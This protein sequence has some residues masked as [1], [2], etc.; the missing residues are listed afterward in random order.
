MPLQTPTLDD[1]KYQDLLDEALA[2]IPVHTPEWTNFNKSDPGVTLIE[3]FAFLTENLLYRT[4]QA[5]ER[6]RRKFLSLLGIPLQP[7]SSAQGLISFTNNLVPPRTITLTKGLE[8]R[9]GQVPFRTEKGLDVLPIEARA[10]YKSYL[11]GVPEQ[12]AQYYNELYASYQGPGGTPAIQVYET[13]PLLSPATDT[14]DLGATVDSSL[15]IALLARPVDKATNP[16]MAEVLRQVREQI[17]GKTLSLGM[18]PVVDETERRLALGMQGDST[19]K[20]LLQYEMP[21]IPASGGLPVDRAPQYQNL[22]ASAATNVLAAP[23]IVEITLPADESQL[24]LW[25]NLDPLE[26]G[27]GDL[28]PALDDTTLNE[29]VITWLRIRPAQRD[30]RNSAAVRAMIRWVGIN[31]TGITQRAHIAN[32]LLPRGSGEPDQSVT[33]AKRPVVPGSVQ[34][35]ITANGKTE[36]WH[37]VDDLFSADPEVPVPDLR[38]PPGTPPLKQ[39]PDRVNVF[40]CDAEA[41]EIRFGDGLHGRR[42]PRDAILRADYDYGVGQA[43]NVGPETITSGPALPAGLKVTNPVRTWGGAEAESVSGGEKQISRYLQHRDRLVTAADFATITLRTPGVTVGRVEVLPTFNPALAPN[44]PG[45]APGAV[46]LMV[47]PRYDAQQPNTP[48]PDRFFL[49]QVCA[50][51]DPRRLVTTEL[52]VR[53]PRYKQIW[54]SVGLQVAPGF[55]FAPVREAVNQA[56]RQFLSSLPADPDALLDT[57]AA[58][59]TGAPPADMRQGWPLG[60]PVVALELLAVAAR[61][62]G[63]QLVNQVLLAEGTTPAVDMVP[64]SGLELPQVMRISVVTGDPVPLDQLRG[65]GDATGTLVSQNVVPVPVIP[66]ECR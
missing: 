47:I 37:E 8:V 48:V 55:A 39:R 33:L 66:A 10:Y 22:E 61:V 26:A 63:V 11:P 28:P 9:A 52:F 18:V 27:V 58:L 64:M 38:Q 49:D 16:D 14:V 53:G 2:R 31:A 42:P 5:P 17:A 7:A 12:V 60:K 50:Y 3:V 46:T 54:L 19:G 65:Q 44:S 6:N 32:E 56:L 24:Q 51:L 21:K 34:L 36:S 23:G 29:R 13:V 62:A 41:G 4:N 35:T 1:R 15:W 45:D 20:T 43:G 59:F 25:N 30:S 40:T 57:P